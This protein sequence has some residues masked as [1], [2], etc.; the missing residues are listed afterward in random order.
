M[1]QSNS[2]GSNFTLALLQ[3]QIILGEGKATRNTVT[4][5]QLYNSFRASLTLQHHVDEGTVR[6]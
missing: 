5:K 2:C 3:P 6:D 1:A 4:A